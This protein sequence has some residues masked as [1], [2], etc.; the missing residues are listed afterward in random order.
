MR[1][2]ALCAAILAA[3][4]L[5]SASAAAL[6]QSEKAAPPAIGGQNAGQPAELDPTKT[7]KTRKTYS[8]VGDALAWLARQQYQD[9][10]WDFRDGNDRD[11]PKDADSGQWR[12]RTG[13]TGLVLI[14]F[15]AAGQTHKTRGPYQKTIAAGLQYLLRRADEHA[16]TERGGVDVVD[17]RGEGG[18]LT[19]HAVA[20]MALCEIYGM[21]GDED[22]G[23]RAQMAVNFIAA[24]QDRRTGGWAAKAGQKPAM[25]VTAWQVVAMKSGVLA[26]LHVDSAVFR[27]ARGFL[28]DLQSEGGAAYGETGPGREP[29]ATAMGL[30]C[31]QYL[32]ANRSDP[33]IQRGIEFLGARGPSKSDLIYNDFATRFLHNAS[34]MDWDRWN[35]ANRPMLISLQTR[36]GPEEGSWW[37]AGEVHAAGGGRLYQTAIVAATLEVYYRYL[38]LFKVDTGGRTARNSP[39]ER[40]G[41]VRFPLPPLSAETWQPSRLVPNTSRLVVGQ[42]QSL[43]LRAMQADIAIDG[44]RARVRL[45]LYFFDDRKGNDPREGA[46]QREGTFQLRLP[47]DASPYCFAFGPTV[48]SAAPRGAG[49]SRGAYALEQLGRAA[50]D[51]EQLAAFRDD[52]WWSQPRPAR[53]V[54][55]EAARTAYGETMRRGVDPALVEWAGEGVFH[56]RV[57]PLEP[58]Q[59]HHVVLGYD[60]DLLRAGDDLE[61][62]VDLPQD[63]IPVVVDIHAPADSASRLTVDPAG[64]RSVAGGRV[65]HHFAKGAKGPIRV[66]LREPGPVV[67]AGDDPQTG[68]YFATRLRPEL[69]ADAA[70]RSPRWAV[71]LVDTSRGAKSPPF[72]L[73]LKLL[74]ALLER[75]RPQIEQFAVLWFNIESR[76]WRDG[77]VPNTPEN[78]GAL[79][80]SADGLT[81][82][83][84]TDLGQA[85]A[86]AASPGWLGKQQPAARDLFLLSDGAVTWGEQDW[87]ALVE[88]VRAGAPGRLFAYSGCRGGPGPH[89]SRLAGSSGGAALC[90]ASEAEIP[91]AATAHRGV[92]WRLQGVRM[93]GAKDLLLAGRP[94][95][96]FP[97]QEVLL[98]GRGAV[99]PADA[100]VEF[101]LARGDTTLTLRTRLSRVVRSE[102]AAR[103][104]GEA[105]VGQLEE[106]GEAT[107]RDAARYA[108]HF[109]ITGRTCS[110]VMLERDDDYRQF[111]V[112]PEQDALIVKQ[113]AASAIVAHALAGLARGLADPKVRFLAW[114]GRAEGSDHGENV[115]RKLPAATRRAVELM[116]EASFAVR[117][118]VLRC[119]VGGN[120]PAL[121]TLSSLV[122]DRPD[123]PA[124]LC[125]LAFSAMEWRFYGQAY[126]LL[127]RTA[128][129]APGDPRTYHLLAR[130]LDDM[131]RADLAMVYYELAY[132]GRFEEDGGDEPAVDVA[133][134]Y[135]R[136]LRRE[137][138]HRLSPD[139]A[140]L[141]RLR[142]A[143]VAA[144]CDL[145][146]AD[147]VV[148]IWWNPDGPGVDLRIAEPSGEEC[149]YDYT[150]TKIGGQ[151]G[152]GSYVL[153]RAAKGKYIIRACYFGYGDAVPAPPPIKVYAAIYENWGTSRERVTYRRGTLARPGV[154]CDLGTVFLDH[155]PDGRQLPRLRGA[156]Q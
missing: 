5:F 119:D 85:L 70:P 11:K 81:L 34:G 6:A 144:E 16:R 63:K 151:L 143:A 124:L 118:P 146:K 141:A 45:D 35:R 120:A 58:Q 110:L 56:C 57:F 53:L 17:L 52:T 108:R 128:D 121:R 24:R 75:N 105:A 133:L 142:L 92:P 137:I 139:V 28:Q 125:D 87:P 12:S 23:K 96:L 69:P 59:L 18:D 15:L 46:F 153:R 117:V 50:S 72:H 40:S 3:I 31:R 100:M 8:A 73:R 95:Y 138:G 82:D 55:R 112:N 36:E 134:D 1:C 107:E 111:A 68:P 39:P 104:Y 84:A 48:F 71:F 130:C 150:R 113:H 74:R 32:G 114:L 91:Q 65:C 49:S 64:Q 106:L 90:V 122:K 43:P 97:G 54:A 37:I 7:G 123:D 67:L 101:T 62:P 94:E 61:L 10:G 127:R 149:C 14:P 147:L 86:E 109:G 140:K 89:L 88:I 60:V 27:A 41:S 21:T 129:L 154:T 93:A 4:V 9:G 2:P 29:A 145:G 135:L 66:R 30:L 148:S 132:D 19:R 102:L 22:V 156:G 131:G 44:F 99:N 103:T 25:S 78:V 115:C 47:G 33:A 136:F 77:F 26:G 116:P 38:P 155:G 83:G 152:P 51:P 98:V 42:G 80:K 126:G 13:A 20:T 79:M 76:W